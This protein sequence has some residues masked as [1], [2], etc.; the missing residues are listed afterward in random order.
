MANP[1]GG[2]VKPAAPRGDDEP[3]NMQEDVVGDELEDGPADDAPNVDPWAVTQL[4]YM[5]AKLEAAGATLGELEAFEAQWL[6]PEWAHDEKVLLLSLGDAKLLI[7][8][9][10][11][12]QDGIRD[13]TTEE[14][15][16]D[17]EADAEEADRLAGIRA[18][19][20]ARTEL[21]PD[22]ILEWAGDDTEKLVAVL[23]VERAHPTPR[24]ELVDAIEGILAD[25]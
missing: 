21:D 20:E 25:R 17:L 16:A 2:G 12:R 7:E 6:D 1:R 11:T 22:S 14:E 24:A 8:L 15:E 18:D 5:R 4:P 23:D 19:A 10:K 13:T 9:E 3:K